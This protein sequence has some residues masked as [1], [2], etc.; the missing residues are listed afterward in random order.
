MVCVP[1]V[2][3]Y[4]HAVQEGFQCSDGLLLS[5]VILYCG[6]VEMWY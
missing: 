6:S 4:V 1:L 3:W 5:L 2:V